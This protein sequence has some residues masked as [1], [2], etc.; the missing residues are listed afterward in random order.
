MTQRTTLDPGKTQDNRNM[1]PTSTYPLRSPIGMFADTRLRGSE[2]LERFI[3][4]KDVSTVLDI[5]A[6]AGHQAAIMRN[7]GKSVT[8]ISLCEP[9]DILVDYLNFAA[10]RHYDGIWASHVLEHQPNVG[11]FLKKC[12]SDLRDSGV[13][14]VSVPPMKHNVVGGHLALWNAG[15]LIYNLVIAG[16]DCSEARV[17]SYDY[18]ISVIVRKKAATLPPDLQYDAGD[19]E[20]ISHFFPVAVRQDFDGRLPDINW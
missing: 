8:C 3:A 18:D 9:T 6:G 11:L 20:K 14:A 10:A 12:F 4:Y 15:L 16:F 5:G 7:A 13:L 1:G 19:I 2:A 17:G